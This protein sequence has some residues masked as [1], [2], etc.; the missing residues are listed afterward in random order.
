M[1]F[2]KTVDEAARFGRESYWAVLKTVWHSRKAQR[3]WRPDHI[4]DRKAVFVKDAALPDDPVDFISHPWIHQCAHLP[5]GKQCHLFYLAEVLNRH[6]HLPRLEDTGE[7]HPLLSQ[8]VVELALR[9]PLY[10][11]L[12]GGKQRALARE[13]FSNH[14]PHEIAERESKGGSTSSSIKAL[15]GG[16]NFLSE[17]LLD[18]RLAR[19]GLLNQEAIHPYLGK[20]SPLRADHFFQFVAAATAEIWL[21]QWEI[22][23]QRSQIATQVV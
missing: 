19:A 2:L 6:R 11:L 20:G 22:P 7:H 5:P 8:P 15:K 21:R 14:V 1:R 10:L 3:S 17:M 9:T 4:R 18:G 16:M 13:T 12:K 23:L